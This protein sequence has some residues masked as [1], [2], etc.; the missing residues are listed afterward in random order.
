MEPYVWLVLIILGI[1][2]EAATAN[3]VAVWFVIGFVF[4]LAASLLGAQM[5]LQIVIAI[6]V[7]IIALLLTRPLVRKLTA[8]N[9]VRTNADRFVGRVGVVT[10]DIL[11][12]SGKGRVEVSGQSWAAAAADGS[13]IRKGESI[14]V[15]SISGVKLMVIKKEEE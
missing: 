5:W 7:S 6:V 1:I 14:I 3:L 10:E 15:E 9:V 11:D 8:R 4:A 12:D 2:L 13:I